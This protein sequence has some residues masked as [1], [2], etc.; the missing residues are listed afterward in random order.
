MGDGPVNAV[1]AAVDKLTGLTGK[2]LEYRLHSVTRGAD[3]VGEVHIQ[4]DFE[5][6][7]QGGK[8]AST[9]V[10]EASL[11]AYLN[12]VNKAI[13][14]RRSRRAKAAVTGA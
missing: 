12:A 6:V 9:D 2:L 14:A 11:R 4:V 13:F 7:A 3:A 1:F 8:G 10:V 5:G